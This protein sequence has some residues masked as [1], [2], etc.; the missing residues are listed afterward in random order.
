VKAITERAGVKLTVQVKLQ[1]T[2]EQTVALPRTLEL[3]N[4][5]ANRLSIAVLFTN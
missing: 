4:A 2:P 5:A 3:A 1:P